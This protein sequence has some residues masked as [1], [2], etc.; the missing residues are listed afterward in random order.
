MVAMVKDS[1]TLGDAAFDRQRAKIEA[2]RSDEG[3]PLIQKERVAKERLIDETGLPVEVAGSFV[4]EATKPAE[5]TKLQEAGMTERGNRVVGYNPETNELVVNDGG[6]QRPYDSAKDGRVMSKNLSQGVVIKLAQDKTA[7]GSVSDDALKLAASQYLVTGKMPALGMGNA[8][9]RQKVLNKA[10]DMAREMGVDP[11]ELP[12]MQAGFG[13]QQQA[14]KTMTNATA[15]F[16][17]FEKGMMANADYAIKL[18]S[19]FPRSKIPPVNT[20]MNAIKTKTGDPNIVRFSNALY[21]AALEYE[22]IRTA[23]TNISSAE[24]SVGA[25]KKAEDLINTAQT[26]EQLKAAVDAMRVD[27]K[28]IINARRSE[29]KGLQSDLASFGK[30]PDEAQP[31]GKTIVR[32]GTDK[33][34]GRKVVQY[35]DGSVEYAR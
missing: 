18:S 8:N 15:N 28:N 2:Q 25:Q 35:S 6:T 11:M 21:A 32:T 9:L 4:R 17:A 10:A 26:H 16:G 14:L 30:K 5:P 29:I 27:A 3:Y 20:V 12:S 7:A 13:A 31:T 34:T 19:R 23:G 1:G 22:K 24:L 33:K